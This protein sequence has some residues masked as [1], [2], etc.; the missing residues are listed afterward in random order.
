MSSTVKK[1]M[2]PIGVIIGVV[3]RLPDNPAGRDRSAEVEQR[4]DASDF[5]SEADRLRA[6]TT[7]TRQPDSGVL[8]R[9]M[10]DER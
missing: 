8:V 6:E 5:W 3:Q 4:P 7:G 1:K 2:Y 9:E 10:R